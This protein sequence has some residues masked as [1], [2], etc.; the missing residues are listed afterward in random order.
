ML[1]SAE[2]KEGNNGEYYDQS[3]LDN[4]SEIASNRELRERLWNTSL[5]MTN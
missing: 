1:A 5:Q 2:E 3:E 4:Y